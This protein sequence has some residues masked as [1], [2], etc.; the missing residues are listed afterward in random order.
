[1]LANDKSPVNKLKNNKNISSRF[2]CNI[3]IIVI[4]IQYY[5]EHIVLLLECKMQL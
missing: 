4:L 2:Q 5:T 3:I 1:M